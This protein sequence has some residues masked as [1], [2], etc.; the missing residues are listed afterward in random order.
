MKRVCRAVSTGH[1]TVLGRSAVDWNYHNDSESHW[2]SWD[3]QGSRGRKLKDSNRKNL[4]TGVR[5][6]DILQL[7]IWPVAPNPLVLDCFFL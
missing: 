3:I 2:C 4:E 5:E 6:I 7:T 1:G